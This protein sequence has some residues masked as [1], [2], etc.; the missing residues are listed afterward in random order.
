MRGTGGVGWTRW[1]RRTWVHQQPPM[2]TSGAA[3]FPCARSPEQRGQQDALSANSRLCSL[4]RSGSAAH[5]ATWSGLPVDLCS[6]GRVNAS[7]A[8][9]DET[10]RLL[11]RPDQ[12]PPRKSSP[13]LLDPAESWGNGR[14]ANDSAGLCETSAIASS[15]KS[16]HPCSACPV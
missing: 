15:L 10:D 4:R 14:R 6:P 9:A 7:T 1:R 16:P 11:P 12:K 13:G 5:L 2:L 3:D 8:S